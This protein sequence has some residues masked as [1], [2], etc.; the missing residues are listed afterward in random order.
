MQ[1][2]RI[3]HYNQP[4]YEDKLGKIKWYSL[5]QGQTTIKNRNS[6]QYGETGYH[7]TVIFGKENYV[8]DFTNKWKFLKALKSTENISVYKDILVWSTAIL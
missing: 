8:I 4:S 3:V 5:T 2:S 6:N 1:L 7:W